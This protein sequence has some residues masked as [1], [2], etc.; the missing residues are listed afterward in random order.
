M[1]IRLGTALVE[2]KLITVD[3]LNTA[4]AEQQKTKRCWARSLFASDS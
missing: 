1:A 3:E 2:E 4:L